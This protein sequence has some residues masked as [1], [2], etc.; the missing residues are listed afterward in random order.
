M[1]TLSLVQIVAVEQD[2]II[3]SVVYVPHIFYV[4]D[5][6]HM[7]V[8]LRIRQSKKIETLQYYE[9]PLWG[10]ILSARV[11]RSDGKNRSLNITFTAYEPGTLTFPVFLLNDAVVS[12]LSVHVSSILERSQ[13]DLAVPMKQLLLPY[14]FPAFLGFLL[15]LLGIPVLLF[16][17]T[18][19]T[20]KVGVRFIRW[21]RARSPLRQCKRE[22]KKLKRRLSE[23]QTR[24]FYE[25]LAR[26]MREYLVYRIS[27]C[28]LSATSHEIAMLLKDKGVDLSLSEVLG[29]LFYQ[30]D[31]VK[32]AHCSVS[33]ESKR[34]DVETAHKTILRL[35][36]DL[37]QL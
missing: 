37:E 16:F 1:C 18:G 33:Q 7:R 36:S 3:Q 27:P 2:S 22:L 21:R 10:K 13:G 32:F 8:R 6:V 23:Y 24:I 15:L 29:K 4:G 9:Q 12:G 26:S 34:E 17:L 35:Q 5:I 11:S 14:T 30:S 25:R 20:K 31:L 19:Y 28:F